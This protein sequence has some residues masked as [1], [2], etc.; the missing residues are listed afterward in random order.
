[1]KVHYNSQLAKLVTFIPN[2]KTIML[3]GAVFT[4]KSELDGKVLEHEKTHCLQ[5][6]DCFNLGIY[7]DVLLLF[8]LFAFNIVN[9][10][11]LY[12]III[13]ILLFY[14]WYGIEYIVLRLKGHDHIEAYRNIGFERQ[15]KWRAETWDKPCEEQNH[16]EQFGWYR[17]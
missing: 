9:W 10:N 2:F 12:L 3:F 11:L 13:P 15:A 1:M 4:E 7:V 17:H 14:A 6:K 16:Y 8:I 5:Y